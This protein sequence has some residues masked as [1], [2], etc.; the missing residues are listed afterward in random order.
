[1]TKQDE[2]DAISCLDLRQVAAAVK[3]SPETLRD[4]ISDGLFPRG[5]CTVDG[6]PYRWTLPTVAAWIAKRQRSRST[7]KPRGRLKKGRHYGRYRP[8]TIL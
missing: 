8:K 2:L 6:G 5:F 4:W 7:R 1:M 3:V